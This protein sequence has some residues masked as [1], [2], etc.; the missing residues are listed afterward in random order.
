MKAGLVPQIV[1]RITSQRGA[2]DRNLLA[3]HMPGNSLEHGDIRFTVDD[4]PADVVVV[5]NYLKYDT[6]ISARRGYVWNWHNEPIS[7]KPFAKGFDRVFTHEQ[8]DDPR[9]EM[10]P[11]ILDWWIGK[12]W[13]ELQSLVPPKKDH[14]LSLIAST[15]SMIPGHLARQKFVTLVE[16]EMPEVDI[17]GEGRPRPLEDKWP[18]L[19]PYRYSIAIEN[20]VKPDYWTEKI[21][22]CF[23]SNT[24]PIYFGAP[25]IGDYFPPESF[26]WL[27]MQDPQSAL[28][29]IR[30]V[31][32]VDNWSKR[33]GPLE[34][35]R[36]RLLEEY[37]L[38]GQIATRVRR[39]R[40]TILSMPIERKRVHGRRMR[41]GGWIRGAGLRG[42]YEAQLQKIKN[43]RSREERMADNLA[44]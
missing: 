29:V 32:E 21:A 6:T 18:G 27:P 30:H 7:R 5:L 17:F 24:V 42:N 19:A 35:A 43:A 20:S 22:D 4:E 41:K 10:A 40:N 25:N 13:D 26:I 23:L 14:N 33:L 34:G 3:S 37:S 15:K 12:T 36:R 1:V 16:K 31:I 39:E 28:E 11:P 8:S 38:F 2:P 9:V 44:P